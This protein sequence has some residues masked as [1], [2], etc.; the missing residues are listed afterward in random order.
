MA[1]ARDMGTPNLSSDVPL[2][3][4]LKDINDNAPAFERTSYKRNIPEDLAGGTSVVQVCNYHVT[5]N[6]LC[7]ERFKINC[8]IARKIRRERRK[9]GKLLS[10]YDGENAI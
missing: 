6:T 2:I 10:I 9:E 4:Y 8:K 1:R 5:C 7:G 3:I